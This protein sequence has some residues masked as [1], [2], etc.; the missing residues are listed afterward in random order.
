MTGLPG[1]MCRLYGTPST[2]YNEGNF[3]YIYM[4]TC[5]WNLV[6]F[7]GNPVYELVSI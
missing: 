7:S 2:P 5:S 3:H 4:Q 1:L 6:Y